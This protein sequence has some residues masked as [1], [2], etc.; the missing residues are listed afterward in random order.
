[1]QCNRKIKGNNRGLTNLGGSSRSKVVMMMIAMESST[2]I[3]NLKPYNPRQWPFVGVKSLL[4]TPLLMLTL[5]RAL[6][7]QVGEPTVLLQGGGRNMPLQHIYKTSFITRGSCHHRQKMMKKKRLT[8]HN[9][10]IE[11]H[12]IT[13]GSRHHR[14]KLMKKKRLTF[15]Y[16]GTLLSK[17]SFLHITVD[18]VTVC[19]CL[20]DKKNPIP[21][22]HKPVPIIIIIGKFCFTQ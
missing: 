18:R 21:S 16:F 8:F 11:P 20:S 14:Q 17:W 4:G 12:F 15:Q 7:E 13:Q 6:S 1:M 3:S 19:N 9:T 5:S 22:L 2:S 10:Y